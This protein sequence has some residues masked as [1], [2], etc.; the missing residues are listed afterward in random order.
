MSEQRY[1][2]TARKYRPQRFDELV[3]QE[4]VTETIRN[5]IRLDRLAHAYLFS[6]PR[7]VG[8][9]TA[10]RILAKAINCTSS[11]EERDGQAEPC[12]ACEHCRTF[13]EGRSLNVIEIDAA[14]NNRVDDIRD[15]RETVRIPPQGARRKVYIVDEVHMLSTAAF[16]ALLKTLEEPPPHVL[17]IFATTEPH[18][19]LP[20]IL[21]RCQRFDFRRIAVPEIVAR[22][23]DICKEENIRADEASL[24]LIARKGDGALRDALSVFDQAVSLCGSD[25]AYA[26]LVKALGVVDIDRYFEV[27]DRIAARDMGG[28]L[29]LIE[30]AIRAGHDLQEFLAGLTEHLRNLLVARTMENTELIEAAEATRKRYAEAVAP[31]SEMDLLR[32][33]TLAANAEST[34]KNSIQPRLKVETILLN[35][36]MI[37][38]GADL[39]EA[40]AKIDRLDAAEPYRRPPGN[41]DARSPASQRS[42]EKTASTAR[43]IPTSPPPEKQNTPAPRDAGP[44]TPPGDPEP[45]AAPKAPPIRKDE[46]LSESAPAEPPSPA[47][48]PAEVPAPVQQPDAS[49]SIADT[50]F[51]KPLIP[52][53]STPNE[54]TLSA[55]GVADL[56]AEVD[57]AVLETVETDTS[58][59][60]DEK[61]NPIAT[62]WNDLLEHV[63]KDKIQIW[64]M[65]HRAQPEGYDNGMIHIAV[66]DDFHRRVL[67]VRADYIT[68]QLK[69]LTNVPIRAMKYV[70]REDMNTPGTDGASETADDFDP[71]EYMERKR[72]ENPVVREIFDQFGGEPV[73]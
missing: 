30:N 57:T 58:G 69:S 17:F 39:R 44:H 12:R 66:P 41:A 54:E 33:L 50:L 67:T 22:L 11:P 62:I 2:V 61:A 25:I 73:W 42:P 7:G 43:K 21:S 72:K 47:A 48:A 18:K 52:R 29:Q 32:L 51:G 70:V 35:M 13:E 10:A 3:A 15:L 4:H 9:T 27:T 64:S 31:F 53:D 65:L 55:A 28:M 24:L 46:H 71:Y 36:A 38:L 34:L 60:P 8:K 16:N 6:G 40:L 14:S 37:T 26:D 56:V 59:I 63:K 20:T 45:K 68:G 49:P 19:V 23:S 1:L 5:A